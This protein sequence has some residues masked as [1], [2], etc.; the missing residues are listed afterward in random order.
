MSPEQARGRPLSD[1]SDIYSLGIVLLEMLQR[2]QDAY[3]GAIGIGLLERVRRAG[4]EPYDFHDRALNALLRRMT[5]KKAGDRPRAA[6][7]VRALDAIVGKPGRTKQ[8]V[9]VTG[10]ALVFAIIA[11]A[12]AVVSE[13]FVSNRVLTGGRHGGRIA[14]L[15]FRNTTN[16]PSLKWVELGMMDFVA[17][18]LSSTNGLLVVASEDVIRSMKNLG[19]ERGKALD[20]AQRRKLLDALDADALIDASVESRSATLS[21]ASPISPT[22]WAYRKWRPA[23]RRSPRITSPSVSIAI[24]ISSGPE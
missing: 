18:T 13:R 4:I 6:D 1:A 17:Q 9:R 7:V 16:D 12:L 15:P 20:E 19:L 2:G 14:I 21:T 11:A 22:P 23:G 3:G 8:R 24:P 5:T 10:I